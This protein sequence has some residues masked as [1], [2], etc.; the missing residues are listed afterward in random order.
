M[1]APFFLQG[2]ASLG[3]GPCVCPS[4]PLLS[5]PCGFQRLLRSQRG[6]G[7]VLSTG[8]LELSA[9]LPLPAPEF[10]QPPVGPPGPPRR[11]C[12]PLA[13]ALP[14]LRELERPGVCGGAWLCPVSIEQASSAARLVLTPSSPA[15]FEGLCLLSLLVGESPTELFQQHC[16][17][18]LRSIQQVLQVRLPP[19]PAPAPSRCSRCAVG[20]GPGLGRFPANREH[21]C[22]WERCGRPLDVFIH[23]VVLI[24]I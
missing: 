13:G 17:S 8:S 12:A 15:R 1:R 16:V 14:A 24:H 7:F 19:A 4:V 6:E 9:P 18:W 2:E 22:T 5:A 3:S 23:G 11:H 10:P 20:A 21:G